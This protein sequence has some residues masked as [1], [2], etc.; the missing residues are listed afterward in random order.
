MRKLYSA[1]YESDNIFGCFDETIGICSPSQLRSDGALVLHGGED[2]SPSIY[3]QKASKYTHATNTPSSRDKDELAFIKRA[4]E[5]GIPI[6]G[7]CRGAQLLCAVAGG[8][9]IQDVTGHNWGKHDLVDHNGFVTLTN[10]IHHQ[11]MN[12]H[13]SKHTIIAW[14]PTM[15]KHYLGEGG[16]Q[17]ANIEVEPEI[18][19]FPELRAIGIQGHPEYLPINNPFVQ[20]CTRKVEEYVL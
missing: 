8:T 10:S 4:V 12:P 19:Y 18:V 13:G 20:Y 1:L 6:I 15:S 5:L 2:I 7:I 14:S 16:N 9:L 3:G 11:M 17:L